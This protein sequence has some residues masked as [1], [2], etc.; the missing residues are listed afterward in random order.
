MRINVEIK[1]PLASEV[2]QKIKS[3]GYATIADYVRFLIRND[4]K[5]M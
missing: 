1:E 3:A 5:N 2:K 4:L